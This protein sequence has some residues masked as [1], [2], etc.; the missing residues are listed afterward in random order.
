MLVYD[1]TS[2][3]KVIE[4]GIELCKSATQPATH[5]EYCVMNRVLQA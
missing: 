1:H 3:I 4:I 2:I 5:L